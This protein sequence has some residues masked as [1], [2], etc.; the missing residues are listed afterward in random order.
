MTAHRIF[1]CPNSADIARIPDL[2]APGWGVVL[3]PDKAAARALLAQRGYSV[4]PAIPRGSDRQAAFL[5]DYLDAMGLMSQWNHSHPLWWATYL[6]ARGRVGS[7]MPPLL[8][9]LSAALDACDRARREDMTLILSGVPWPVVDALLPHLRKSGITVQV[10]SRPLARLQDEWRGRARAWKAL[11]RDIARTMRDVALIRPLFRDQPKSGLPI[12]LIKSFAYPTSIQADGSYRELFFGDL[13]RGLTDRLAGRAELVT[14]VAASG[15]KHALFKTLRD[16]TTLPVEAL[17]PLPAVAGRAI[18]AI[19]HLLTHRFR[20]AAPVEMAGCDIA[21]LLK[22]LLASGGWRFDFQHLMIAEAARRLG[23]RRQLAACLLTHE[24]IP[25]ERLM[26]RALK[27]DHPALPIIGYQHAAFPPAAAGMFTPPREAGLVPRPDT[28]LTTGPEAARIL[29]SAGVPDPGRI[30]PL[31]AL[32]FGHLSDL[33]P[34]PRPVGRPTILVAMEGLNE[35]AEMLDYALAQARDLPEIRFLVKAHPELP[36]PTVLSLL[37]RDEADLPDNVECAPDSLRDAI[38]GSFAILYWGTTVAMEAVLQGRPVI[39]F[40]RGDPITYDPLFAMPAFHSV[41]CDGESIGTV[42]SSIT[43]WSD[44][45]YQSQARQGAAYVRSFL[46]PVV[47]G[48]RTVMATCGLDQ[49]QR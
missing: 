4:L 16:R 25:W 3:G 45:E 14:L 7:P 17:V 43:G 29:L 35:V 49:G 38:L 33:E 37:G 47:E 46:A 24:N 31:G 1:L 19:W 13:P 15:N 36:L 10:V 34:G 20:V 44:D 42:V 32:R 9:A 22:R 21:P 41:V 48:E 39:H 12:L 30:Q 5:E 11:A 40:D 8:H 26:I 28:V 6:S 23:R 18:G 27:Q 2:P